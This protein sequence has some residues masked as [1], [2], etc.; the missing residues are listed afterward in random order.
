M[1]PLLV[2]ECGQCWESDMNKFWCKICQMGFC[3]EKC[4]DEREESWMQTDYLSPHQWYNQNKTVEVK[5][6]E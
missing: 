6:N 5:R 2:N 4:H 1:K 3:S